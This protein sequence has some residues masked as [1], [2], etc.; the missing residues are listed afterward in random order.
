MIFGSLTKGVFP[1]VSRMLSKYRIPRPTPSPTFDEKDG[2]YKNGRGSVNGRR[3]R[4]RIRVRGPRDRCNV[5]SEST[6]G[7]RRFAD[8]GGGGRTLWKP[9]CSR[10]PYPLCQPGVARPTGAAAL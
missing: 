7:L 2:R 5:D 3:F 1:I 9:I 6:A 8:A 4:T 10:S